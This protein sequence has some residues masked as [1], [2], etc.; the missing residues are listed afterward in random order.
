[1]EAVKVVMRYANGRI[2]KGYTNDFFPNKPMF[3]VRPIESQPTDK[4]VEVYLKELKAIFFVKDF[5]GNPAYNEKKDF[6]ENQQSS[7]RKVEVT[8]K[9]GEVLV[10]TTLGYDPNRLGF[11]VTPIDEQSNNLRAF[12]VAAAVRKFRFL[13]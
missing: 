12:V 2:I 11:F 4:D 8:F 1:M 7:G 10:G 13:Q 6:V 3:H 9:D 5:M